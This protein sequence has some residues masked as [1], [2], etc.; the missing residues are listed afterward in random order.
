MRAK[1]VAFCEPSAN[2]LLTKIE[3]YGIM[4]RVRLINK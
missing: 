1:S 3:E 4:V 2:Q